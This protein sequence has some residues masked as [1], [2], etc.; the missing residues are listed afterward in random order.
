MAVK[1]SGHPYPQYA[2]WRQPCRL[3]QTWIPQAARVPL[4][5]GAIRTEDTTAS[6]IIERS[7]SNTILHRV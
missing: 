6:K 5:F 3:Q 4:Q 7:A 2:L 1:S